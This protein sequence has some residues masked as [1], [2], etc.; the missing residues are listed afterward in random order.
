M[1]AASKVLILAG[2]VLIAVGALLYLAPSIPFLGRLPGD[3]RV[4][5]HGFRLYLPL[6]TCLLLSLVLS[7][8]LYLFGRLR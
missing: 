6:T 2:V 5:R 1:P 3:I 4:E 7:G 8:L